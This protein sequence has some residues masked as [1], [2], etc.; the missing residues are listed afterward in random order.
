MLR[1]ILFQLLYGLMGS[2]TAYLISILYVEYRTR[3]ARD[4]VDFRNHVIQ[5]FKV[6]EGL[7]E[8]HWR[9]VGLVFN[10]TFLLFGFVIR[11][12][13]YANTMSLSTGP[14]IHS[15]SIH[16]SLNAHLYVAT[17]MVSL[18][19]ECRCMASTE[20]VLGELSHPNVVAWNAMVTTYFRSGDIAGAGQVFDQ[21]PVRNITTWNLMLARYMKGGNPGEARILF[22][23]IEGKD[24]VSWNTMIVGFASH[25]YFEEAFGLFRELMRER[26]SVILQNITSLLTFF[27][28]RFIVEW[29]VA[30]L[31]LAT[32][33]L[34]VLANF[35]QQLSLKGF[36]GD[37]A[38][39][40]AKTSMIAGEG[41]SNIRTVAAFN[42][43]SKILSLFQQDLRITQ[44]HSLNCSQISGSLFGFS[45]L[46]A[47]YGLEA[48]ILWYGAHL[49]C[50]GA[51]T[52]SRVMKVYFVVLVVTANSVAE[53]VSLAP[54]I[55]R[56]G[57]STRS[58]FSIINSST[59]VDSDDPEVEPVD[60]IR[61]EIKL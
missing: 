1:D 13:H 31:I 42:A 15:Q 32:F 57:E 11:S 58:V 52:F 37:T 41:V 25:C 38:K 23:E 28:I 54:E 19:A 50:S 22:R 51:S 24:Q 29:R 6:I 60:S 5:W 35:A 7:L 56:G 49:V 16:Y 34:I 27:I 39:A 17:M 33:P 12:I 8:T 9:K 10:C 55:V 53:T 43:Q 36:A 40:H 46:I 3:K 20:K 44:R 48:L 30:L 45:Q 2:W 21:M 61:G 26:I 18:Y 59:R 4:K 47:L 14:Q